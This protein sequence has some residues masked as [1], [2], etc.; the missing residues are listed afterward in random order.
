MNV[1]SFESK[2][3]NL[4]NASVH[5]ERTLTQREN[6]INGARIISYN[7]DMTTPICKQ[8][9]VMD[10]HQQITTV[11]KVGTC[12]TLPCTG[13]TWKPTAPTIAGVYTGFAFV[14]C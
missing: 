8:L 4:M 5:I 14:F 6:A 9:V 12:H 7:G 3:Y 2:M 13:T 10:A 11:G 1:Q